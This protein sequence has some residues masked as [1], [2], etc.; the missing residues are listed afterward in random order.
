MSKL[1]V[2]LFLNLFSKLKI[3]YE[4]F[5]L[6]IEGHIPSLKLFVLHIGTHRKLD[7]PIFLLFCS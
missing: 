2:I 3:E 6:N 7:L 1:C 4:V 5:I